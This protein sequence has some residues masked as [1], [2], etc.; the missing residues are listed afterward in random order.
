MNP[1]EDISYGEFT[2]VLGRKALTKARD[3]VKI[4]YNN[5]KCSLEDT[6]KLGID[7]RVLMQP[8]G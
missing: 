4:V 5:M 6:G 7:H 3:I 1:N 8:D 2:V